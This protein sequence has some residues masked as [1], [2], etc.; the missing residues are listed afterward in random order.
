M[1]DFLD[2]WLFSSR[3]VPHGNCYLWQTPLIGLHVVSD[4]LIAIAY[5]SIP[6][7]LFYFV[8]QRQGMPFSSIFVMFG[9]F[10]VAC[11]IGHLLD[12][13][14]LWF[15]HYWLSGLERA[16][17]A[18]ISCYTALRL[19]ELMP[20][21]L[22][23]R[24]PEELEVLNRQLQTEVEAR[25]RSQQIL[26][27]LLQGTSS[28][29]GQAFFAALVENLATTLKVQSVLVAERLGTEPEQLRSL[30]YW[31]QG[32]PRETV[33]YAIAGMPSQSVIATG[34]PDYIREGVQAQFPADPSLQLI[35]AACH[36][37][38]PLLDGEQAVL[39]VICL[40]HDQPL[41]DPDTAQ[42][43]VSLFA[44]KAATELQ[45]QYAELALRQARDELE[46]QVAARTL[47]LN[48][49]NAKLRLKIER[50]Q[51]TALTIQQMRQSLAPADIFQAT[52]R[53]LRQALGCDRVIVYRFNPDWSGQIVAEAVGAGWR[54]LLGDQDDDSPWTAKALEQDRCTVKLLS[55]CDLE[56]QDTYLQET[57][58]GIYRQGF[59]YLRVDDVQAAG[60]TP[61]YL[62]LLNSMAARAYLIVPIFAGNRLWGLLASYQNSGPK[63]WQADDTRTAT[64]VG[65]QLGVAIYQA[66]LFQSL[67]DQT[68][69][70]RLAKEAADQAS[71]AKSEFLANMSHELRTPLNAILGFTQLMQGDRSLSEH[72]QH[73]VGIINRSGDHLLGLINDILEMSKI[74]AGR[75]SLNCDTFDLHGL[76]GTLRDLF[77]LKAAAKDL[78]LQ[79]DY[80]ATVP[81][82]IHSD[83]GKLRQ[84]LLNLLSNALK[85][86]DAGRVSLQVTARP[87]A[88]E[89][90]TVLLEF[91]VT[92][93]G[94][95][96]APE[97]QA[98]LFEA[99]RQTSAGI[100]SGQGTGLGLPISQ[101][102][103]RLLGGD[104]QVNSEVGH[105]SCF[106]FMIRAE[107]SEAAEP[108]I[109]DAHRI[110]GLAP[111]QPQYRIALA[112]DNEQNRQLVRDLLVP[113]GFVVREAVNGHEVVQLW[114]AWQ[115]HLIL[116][117]IQMPELDGYAATRQIRQQD[118]A[119]PIIALSASAF[120][121]SRQAVMAVG[122]SDFIRK[123]FNISELLAKLQR[124]LE[125]EYAYDEVAAGT[126][127]PSER[128]TAEA[129]QAQL[130]AQPQP[131][132]QSLYQAAGFCSDEQAIALIE[133]LPASNQALVDYLDQLVQQYS[134]DKLM[135]LLEPL[136]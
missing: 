136:L 8:R 20:Q 16:W 15:P 11:G 46:E 63:V 54:S 43:V 135:T 40:S 45:R 71:R 2:A 121:E 7:M 38:V 118:P 128:L 111:G 53:E 65:Q 78:T 126:P 14:T 69:E 58:G 109:A 120:E 61:C 41:P 4:A 95:G 116:M 86:T 12:I 1:L 28:V 96:I 34:Q 101:Q 25:Q 55:R 117:D 75:Q 115:P 106:H 112:E 5:F 10:I 51:A 59:D 94:P 35:N 67:Q 57:Q 134:F 131:W 102:Y 64:Q 73:Y 60:F 92:D 132:L 77:A 42:A 104:L 82:H 90:N 32:R 66:E 133:Q 108:A 125:L 81:R 123:P 3:Y 84:V 47:E 17:T 130:A 124:H 99:F 9:L 85:F 30:A 18:F 22:A 80:D 89:S 91:A 56:V 97:E 52:T 103:V 88:A 13:W 127:A 98:Q 79:V 119:V 113:L 6:A 23:L 44:S 87:L 21:F 29:T 19:V 72:N 37:C 129:A 26:Q 114:Q 83:G 74:E 31:C 49:A 68:E 76:L 70:L 33:T 27:T 50:E 62:E 39:G 100:K 107:H 105:G 93:T 110:T 122:C 48:E 24:S 36:L